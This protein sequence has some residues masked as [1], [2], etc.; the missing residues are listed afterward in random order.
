MRI[1]RAAAFEV[2]ASMLA[3]ELCCTP[4]QLRDGRVHV[5]PLAPDRG[6]ASMHHRSWPPVSDPQVLVV[7]MSDGGVVGVSPRWLPWAEQHWRGQTRPLESLVLAPAAARARRAG[8]VPR[9]PRPNFVLDEDAW[10]RID[11]PAGIDVRVEDGRGRLRY[12][13][14]SWPNAWVENADVLVTVSA[15]SAGRLVGV[16]TAIRMNPSLAEIGV[17]VASGFRGRGV[18]AAVVSAVARALLDAGV[19]PHY[20]TRPENLNSMRTAGRAGF[21]PAFMTFNTTR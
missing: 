13:Q 20:A 4:Q 7:S 10:R 1:D 21:Y 9:G 5:V 2:V 14:R 12:S 8:L 15:R 11:A 6:E 18:G 3:A 16:A 19:V 17:D